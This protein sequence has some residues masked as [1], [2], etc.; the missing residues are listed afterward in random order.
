MSDEA[1]L[2]PSVPIGRPIANTQVYVLDP[3]LLPVPVGVAEM[4]A[5]GDGV[6][7]GYLNQPELTA[8]RFIPDPFSHAGN[9]RLYRTGDQV[10]W[11]PGNLE[12]WA[13]WIPR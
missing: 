13:D 2:L 9:G 8:E 12:F 5:G 7:C 3:N 11:R 1:A 4:F 6:A 10:R